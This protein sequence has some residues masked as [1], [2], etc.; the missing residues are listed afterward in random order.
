MQLHYDLTG[1]EELIGLWGRAP[2][3]VQAELGAAMAE[4]DAL[5]ERGVK[6]ETPTGASGGGAGGLKGSIFSEER[7][8]PENVIGIVGTPLS[9]AIPVE[10]GTKPHFPPIEPLEDWVRAKLGVREDHEVHSAAFLI[11]RAIAR[12]GTLAVGMFHRT[13]AANEHEVEER[14]AQARLRIVERLGGAA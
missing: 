4:V 12:R 9:Y 7:I 13:F 1:G 8:G 3:I 11:A 10:L 2:Q 5:L 6:E 14:F